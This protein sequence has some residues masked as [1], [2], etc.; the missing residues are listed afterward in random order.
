MDPKLI[1]K[2]QQILRSE[3]LDPYEVEFYLVD[4]DRLHYLSSGGFPYMPPYWGKGRDYLRTKSD[5]ESGRGKIHEVVFNTRPN[6]ALLS[7]SSSLPQN[8]LTVVHVFGHAHVYK[9][10]IYQIPEDSRPEIG[11]LKAYY[12]RVWDYIR[13]Y[14]VEKV[15]PV[16]ELGQALAYQVVHADKPWLESPKG[17]VLDPLYRKIFDL[18]PPSEKAE[19]KSAAYKKLGVG[20]R[21]LSRYLIERSPLIEDWQKDILSIYADLYGKLMTSV[22][23]TKVLHEGF[24]TWV[25]RKYTPLVSEPEWALEI[26]LLDSS[27][28]GP[29][30]YL[31][32]EEVEGDDIRLPKIVYISPYSLGY[33]ILSHLESKRGK[34]AVLE[35]VRYLDDKELI[36]QHADDEW[37]F[38]AFRKAMTSFY[39][40]DA[41]VLEEIFFSYDNWED[42]YEELR[43]LFLSYATYNP[44]Q[45]V[46]DIYVDIYDPGSEEDKWY[47]LKVRGDNLLP[48]LYLTSNDY[49]VESY[50]RKV[51]SLMVN[52]WGG[53]VNLRWPRSLPKE[54]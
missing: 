42:A 11:E 33:W 47:Y 44:I 14:G 40:R 48:E 22:P 5:Y 46:P 25:H 2:A 1:N 32:W 27:L 39:A 28:L 49:L 19:D 9:Q 38:T 30:V 8:L 37:Y 24:S 53:S 43:E 21:N 18:P 20:I 51:I 3:G 15:E 29:P 23:R 45:A 36:L 52:V 4:Q 13:T 35:A 34:E 6:L 10:N 17:Q 31:A 26:A 7:N 54:E 16:I 12:D 50:A 41:Q